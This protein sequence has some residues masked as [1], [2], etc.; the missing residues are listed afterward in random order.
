M[1]PSDA[2]RS[3]LAKTFQDKQ[4]FQLGIMDDAAEC[5]VSSIPPF[6]FLLFSPPLEVVFLS[7]LLSSCVFILSHTHTYA[8]THTER[9]RESHTHN[10]CSPV[11]LFTVGACSWGLFAD[12]VR[13]FRMS[14]GIFTAPRTGRPLRC[15]TVYA[16]VSLEGDCLGVFD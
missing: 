13:V 14:I 6:Y 4:R 15:L 1:L 5:F 11:I 12:I 8:N 16:H 7:F 9:Q 2:L 10:Y 3:A